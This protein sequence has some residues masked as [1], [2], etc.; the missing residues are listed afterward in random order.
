MHFSSVE[1]WAARVIRRHLAVITAPTQSNRPAP[2]PRVGRVAGSLGSRGGETWRPRQGRGSPKKM[3]VSACSSSCAGQRRAVP[4]E[5]ITSEARSAAP[6]AGART[7]APA[8]LL[9]CLSLAPCR[10]VGRPGAEC[11]CRP[12]PPSCSSAPRGAGRLRCEF[13]R[14]TRK[15]SR[16][17]A[18]P[19]ARARGAG[20]VACA[21]PVE[22]DD[23]C[24]AL[25][26]AQDGCIPRQR[27]DGEGPLRGDCTR[28]PCAS[29][30]QR[31]S[32]LARAGARTRALAQHAAP[33][34]KHT[35][36]GLF[37]SRIARIARRQKA[38]IRAESR[39]AH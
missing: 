2:P 9:L 6:R 24:H 34:R 33:P 18:T 25:S 20:S 3:A 10:A 28:R 14:Q 23:G 1:R 7:R 39:G 8:F 11:G 21:R 29:V 31:Q 32:A 19:A 15:C 30:R 12:A 13:R 17:A 37:E 4:S 5:V 26:A 36:P 38:A 16:P 35:R 27:G 22:Q